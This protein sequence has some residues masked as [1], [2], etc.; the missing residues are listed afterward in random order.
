MGIVMNANATE[1]EIRAV[2]DRVDGLGM[3]RHVSRGAERTVVGLIGDERPI[4]P[5]PLE[6][7]LV[8]ITERGPAA[9]AEL[10]RIVRRERR[11]FVP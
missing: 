6:G 9:L 2:L 7:E 5:Q 11:E 8:R 3:R 4:D 10:L 1:E